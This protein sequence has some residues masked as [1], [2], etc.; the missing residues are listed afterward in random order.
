VSARALED[1]TVV[2]LPMTAFQEVF[3]EYPDIFIRVVQVIMVRLQRVTFTALHQYLGLSTEL[4]NPVSL[5]ISSLLFH[6]LACFYSLMMLCFP[7]SVHVLFLFYILSYFS[8]STFF[9]SCRKYLKNSM[10]YS[11]LVAQMYRL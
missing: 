7:H 5:H 9:F 2:R 10:L 3:Q 4:M 8:L 6:C 11:P 1:S